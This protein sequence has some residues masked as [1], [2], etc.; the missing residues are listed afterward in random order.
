MKVFY[1]G[2]GLEGCY[3][4]RCL[5]PLQV[6]G[7]DGDRTTFIANRMTPENK[8]K[9]AKDADIV[10]FHR[11]EEDGKLE[12]MRLLKKIGKKIVFDNDDTYKDNGGI[13]F[14]DYFNKERVERGLRDLNIIIDEAIG[15]S[16]LV[17][18][19]TEFLAEEYRKINPNVVVLPNYID[20]FYFP[21]PLRNETDTIRIGITGSL[22]LTTDADLIKPIMEH[23]KDNPK[24]KF[25]LLSLPPDKENETYQKLYG[26]DYKFWESMDIE[27][28]PF[29]PASEYYE[30]LNNL[31]LDLAIIPRADN[32]FNR[33]KSN[34]KFLEDSM[35]EIPCV[36]QA[37]KTGDSPYQVNPED[38]K[39]MILA[40]GFD[41]FITAIDKLIAD[42][43]YRRELGAKAHEYVEKNYN[44]ENNA[45][46][47]VDA[48]KN[49]TK[50]K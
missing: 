26:E 21:E 27:W 6:N 10:V 9:A 45:Y 31:K 39:Y 32:Y 28:Q 43:D 4:V 48:Y 30:T 49:L 15:L 33:C 19:S 16:D 11:P 2:S 37:F 35:L 18:C 7:W 22:A 12:L 5:F 40:D 3:N 8:A 34:L 17:T 25:V 44:I 42:K 47:W 23:Y 50:I 46:K 41:E 38:S 24:I 29:V 36:C 20:P 14:T 13:K 1:V